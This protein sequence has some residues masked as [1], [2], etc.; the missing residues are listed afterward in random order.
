M[1]HDFKI[2]ELNGKE[3]ITCAKPIRKNKCN[4]K[5][6]VQSSKCLHKVIGKISY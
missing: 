6:E 4:S 5:R 1:D 3:S 2:L